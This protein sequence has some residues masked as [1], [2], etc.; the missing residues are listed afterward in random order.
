MKRIAVFS[1]VAVL[2]A[3]SAAP[4]FAVG[5]VGTR[6]QIILSGRLTVGPGDSVRNVV[7]FHGPVVIQGAVDGSVVVF[8]GAVTVSGTV[9]HNIV[10]FR[11]PV[12]ITSTGRVGDDIRSRQKPVVEQGGIVGGKIERMN[13]TPTVAWVRFGF[14]VAY[15]LS[16]LALGMLLVLLA[17]RALDA[18]NAAGRTATGPAIG[19]GLFVFIGLPVLAVLA[20]A[21]L[22]GIPLGFA[23]LLALALLYTV[24][25][26]AGAWFLGRALVPAP[27]NRALALLVGWGL[28]A[29]AS[30]IPV[31]GGLLW[32]AATVFGL[33]TLL[34]ATW[35]ARG[36]Q[37]VLTIPAATPPSVPAVPVG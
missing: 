36:T 6:D 28:F 11:G 13:V 27:R 37:R 25:Y 8:D 31:V 12:T 10:S 26:V 4:A 5:G 18:A 30:L 20:I 34:V 1:V 22:V 15:A 29:A 7:V 14:Y 19:W 32:F 16:V 21:T 2:L 35:R 24:G 17:P 3:F 9:R 23:L 33:G